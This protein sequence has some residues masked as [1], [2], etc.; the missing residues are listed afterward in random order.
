M[1]A[2]QTLT[3]NRRTNPRHRAKRSVKVACRPGNLELGKNLAVC[4]LD[5]SE[6]GICLL[7]RED[8]GPGQDVTVT[9]EGPGHTRPLKLTGDIAWSVETADGTYCAGIRFRKRIAPADVMKLT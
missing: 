2:T 3:K 6:T 9:A 7:L 5:V 4:L 8:L 1:T